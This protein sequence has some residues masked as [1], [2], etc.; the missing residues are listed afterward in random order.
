M[1]GA[2]FPSVDFNE[3]KCLRYVFETAT[4][5]RLAWSDKKFLESLTASIMD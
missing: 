1:M 3:N 4:S 2:A 5:P